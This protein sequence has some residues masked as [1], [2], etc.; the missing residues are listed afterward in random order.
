MDPTVC[1]CVVGVKICQLESR[2]NSPIDLIWEGV[3]LETKKTLERDY[4]PTV[5]KKSCYYLNLGK[6]LGQQLL[7]MNRCFGVPVMYM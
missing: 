6:F 5:K 1:G 3:T 7:N 4:F 2:T